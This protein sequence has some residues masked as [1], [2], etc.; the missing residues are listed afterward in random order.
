MT[1]FHPNI[2][3]YHLVNLSNSKYNT[4]C[5]LKVDVNSALSNDTEY[6]YTTAE[7]IIAGLGATFQSIAGTILNFLVI[8]ALI[9]TKSIRH[10]YIT[11]SILSLIVTDLLFSTIT[12]PMLAA[13]YLIG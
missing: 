4:E 5:Y 9:R 11:P 8:V 1:C 13:R 7:S 3:H 12:L 10:E 6:C 2:S